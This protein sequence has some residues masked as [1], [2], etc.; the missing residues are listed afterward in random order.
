MARRSTQVEPCTVCARSDS[1]TMCL[2]PRSLTALPCHFPR[3]GCDALTE[4]ARGKP[5]GHPSPRSPVPTPP[6]P[7]GPALPPCGPRCT[8][9]SGWGTVAGGVGGAVI[10][11]CSSASCC[12]IPWSDGSVYA[13]PQFLFQIPASSGGEKSPKTHKPGPSDNRGNTI[14]G[15]ALGAS[16]ALSPRC[17]ALHANK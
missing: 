9:A 16:A 13:Q 12:K 8:T 1:V 11:I 5:H 4:V 14:T 15:N 2:F 10:Y 7:A 3:R 17:L 6:F